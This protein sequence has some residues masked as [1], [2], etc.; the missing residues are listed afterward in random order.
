VIKQ[1]ELD[2]I[3]QIK[4]ENIKVSFCFLFFCDDNFIALILEN[5]FK[6]QFILKL[7]ETL[8][9]RDREIDQKNNESEGVS[10]FFYHSSD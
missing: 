2:Y 3:K 9:F 1:E 6:N 4:E 10:F 5:S 7:K 8:R